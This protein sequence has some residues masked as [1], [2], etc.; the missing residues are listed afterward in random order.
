MERQQLYF[1]LVELFGFVRFRGV[2]RWSNRFEC[3]MCQMEHSLL[4][5]RFCLGFSCNSLVGLNEFVSQPL[6]IRF[7]V[8][9]I[10]KWFY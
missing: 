4:F 9:G 3:L 8:R 6:L 1:I 2:E 10:T 7:I 5:W